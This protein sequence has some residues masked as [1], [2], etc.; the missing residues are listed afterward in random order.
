MADLREAAIYG[1]P[2]ARLAGPHTSAIIARRAGGSNRG[3]EAPLQALP[4][5]RPA[6]P[7]RELTQSPSWA[8]RRGQATRRDGRAS[9]RRERRTDAVLCAQVS[10]SAIC[11]GVWPIQ[12]RRTE[13]AW[14]CIRDATKETTAADIMAHSYILATPAGAATMAGAT[15]TTISTTARASGIITAPAARRPSMASA[16]GFAPERNRRPSWRRIYGSWRLR[17]RRCARRC[18][19]CAPLHRRSGPD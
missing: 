8:R 18:R 7:T 15:A 16:V 10:R 11:F 4:G 17:P 12:R 5:Y 13:E 9:C 6:S 19:R 1:R 3:Q 14:E 2:S